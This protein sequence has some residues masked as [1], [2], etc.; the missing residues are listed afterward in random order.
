MVNSSN[1]NA[2]K[3]NPAIFEINSVLLFKE[4]KN[5]GADTIDSHGTYGYWAIAAAHYEVF[6]GTGHTVQSWEEGEIRVLRSFYDPYGNKWPW[7]GNVY[8]AAIGP[9]GFYSGIYND[10]LAPVVEILY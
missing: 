8:Y 5:F 6:N 2:T 10:G 9:T 7:T 4:F 1:P 3:R